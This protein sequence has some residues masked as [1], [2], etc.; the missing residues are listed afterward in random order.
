MGIIMLKIIIPPFQELKMDLL[1]DPAVSRVGI[2]TIEFI[3]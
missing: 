3:P 2:F 1:F